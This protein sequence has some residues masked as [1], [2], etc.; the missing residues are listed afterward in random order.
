MYISKSDDTLEKT[1]DV[2]RCQHRFGYL[3]SRKVQEAARVTVQVHSKVFSM[4]EKDV[5]GAKAW[6]IKFHTRLSELDPRVY[7]PVD[8][9]Q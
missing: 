5:E 4:Y 7:D 3:P 2:H 1:N 6:L 9:G 8:Q